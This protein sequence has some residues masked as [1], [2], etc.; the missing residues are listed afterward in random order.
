MT[1]TQNCEDLPHNCS[2]KSLAMLRRIAHGVERELCAAVWGSSW[3][4]DRISDNV[5]S[6]T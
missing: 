4:D 5:Y 2:Q 1:L 6:V 3:C